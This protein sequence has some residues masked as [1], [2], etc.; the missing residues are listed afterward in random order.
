MTFSDRSEMSHACNH[1]RTREASDK[2]DCIIVTYR[3]ALLD[4]GSIFIFCF[5]VFLN[6]SIIIA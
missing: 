5:G 2:V 4:I 3:P 6:I 1:V